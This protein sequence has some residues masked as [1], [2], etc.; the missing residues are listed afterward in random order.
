MK[1]HDTTTKQV[2][3]SSGS[4]HWASVAPTGG[5][6]GRWYL[7]NRTGW[8]RS[9]SHVSWSLCWLPADLHKGRG[10]VFSVDTDDG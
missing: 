6:G 1:R 2:S 3:N 8:D 9:L 4:M 10:E 7:R 5:D